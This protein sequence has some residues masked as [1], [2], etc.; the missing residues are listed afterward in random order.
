V[1]TIYPLLADSKPVSCRFC[2][3]GQAKHIATDEEKKITFNLCDAHLAEYQGEHDD[4]ISNI[5][6]RARIA[7]DLSAKEVAPSPAGKDEVQ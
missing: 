3:T 5:T 7:A 1:F 2:C 6:T 4:I